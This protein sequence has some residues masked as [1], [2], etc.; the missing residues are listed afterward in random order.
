MVKMIINVDDE[1]EDDNQEL[2]LQG[3]EEEKKEM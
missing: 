1:D 3:I 2:Y